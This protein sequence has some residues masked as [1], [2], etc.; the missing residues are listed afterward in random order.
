MVHA[1]EDRDRTDQPSGRRVLDLARSRSSRAAR[2]SGR[3]DP[4][5]RSRGRRRAASRRGIRNRGDLRHGGPASK[6]EGR[7]GCGCL[8]RPNRDP[9]L[10]TRPCGGGLCLTRAGTAFPHRRGRLRRPSP[11]SWTFGRRGTS[12]TFGRRG[13][14]WTFGRRGTS[15]TFGRRG[16]SWTS[17]ARP[18][19]GQSSTGTA[20][21]GRDSR[22]TGVGRCGDRREK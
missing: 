18:S 13:T 11:P 7:T 8:G 12:W 6:T 20:P 21:T 16:T 15:W 9:R 5:A 17:S 1:P 2:I 3:L 4:P 19:P 14:S 22:R 10:R